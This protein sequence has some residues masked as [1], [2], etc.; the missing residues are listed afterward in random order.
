MIKK[1]LNKLDII[2]RNRKKA[3]DQ[4][5]QEVIMQNFFKNGKVP[6]SEG[7][8][9]YKE[10]AIFKSIHNETL[11]NN[12]AKQKLP[13]S[14]GH[15]LDERVVEYSWIFSNMPVESVKMLDAGS[16]FN[17]KYIIEHP[18]LKDKEITI[19][20]YAPE[21]VS[22]FKKRISYVY[23]DLRDMYFQDNTFDLVISQSTI[24]H[25][26]MDNSIYG[27]TLE[28]NK[29]INRKS[30]EYVKAVSEMLRVLKSNGTLLLTFPF[31][32][33]ENHGFFQQFDD[34]M[35]GK[36][37]SILKNEG[38]MKLS[39]FRYLPDGWQSCEQSDCADIVSFNPHTGKGKLND[40]AAHCRSICCIKFNKNK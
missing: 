7:Y 21:E 6:W 32:K 35:L 20:T 17:F 30:Y 34:E 37:E 10:D 33:F 31:G 12:L 9:I 14:F 23:G 29:E 16:T 26:D 8:A 1:I 4:K 39:F 11:L 19:F 22:F 25:I 2:K 3:E 40:G 15:R 13:E 27:Y 38:T 36:I 5:K 18:L 24:E 28:H